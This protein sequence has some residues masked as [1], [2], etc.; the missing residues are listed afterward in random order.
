MGDFVS[1]D[2]GFGLGPGSLMLGVLPVTVLTIDFT[3]KFPSEG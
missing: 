2:L 3:A 1:G